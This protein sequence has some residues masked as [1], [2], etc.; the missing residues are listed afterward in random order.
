MHKIQFKIDISPNKL[1]KVSPWFS[2]YLLIVKVSIMCGIFGYCGDADA[3]ETILTGLKRLEYRGYDSWGVAVIGKDDSK[4]I[5]VS[6]KI[7]A[8]GNLQ[9]IKKLPESHIGIG[10]TRWATH[11]GVTELNAHPHFS[12]DNSFVL[13]QNGI[14]ENY[15]DL[16]KQLESD[17]YKFKTQT[18]TEVIVKLIEQELL[19][20]QELFL[21]VRNAFLKLNGRNTII[22]LTADN[23]I[24]AVRNGSPLVIGLGQN[25]VFFASDALS[26]ADKTD[27]VVFVENMQMIDYQDNDLSLFELESLKKLKLKKN[28][29]DHDAVEVSKEGFDHYM[30]KEILEQ[31]DTLF[32]SVNYTEEEFHDLVKAA[33]K[34]KNIFVLGSGGAF[35]AADQVA[36]L[37]RSIAGVKALGLRPYEINS[38]LQLIEDNDLLVVISQSGETADN[39]E[40]IEL[41]D[42]KI[43]IAST[44]NMIGSTT[45]RIS[46][47]PFYSRTGPEICV[48]STKSGTAQVAFGYLLANS[49]IGQHN[50]AKDSVMRLT[51]YLKEYLSDDFLR[52]IKKIA[53]KIKSK[54]HAFLL[55][56]GAN[57]QVA[58]LGALNIKEASYMHAEGFAAG[59]LKHG[60]IALIEKGTPVISFVDDDQDREYMIGATAEVKA[61]GAYVIGIGTEN[62]ELFDEFIELP[63]VSGISAAKIANVIPCQVLAY[64]IAT[65]RGFDPDKPRNLAKSVT[66]K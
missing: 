50:I 29:L 12:N 34:A 52:D 7:G 14:V 31:K 4:D 42:K 51:D 58:L 53:K 47:Y 25:E 41:I 11:G 49:I 48:L 57:Y 5:L 56:K 66:V 19:T 44:V 1:T 20:E 27:E 63:T 39:L 22:L 62:N 10:H 59:E 26:F 21:A 54:K 23:R 16:K 60:V 2:E 28:K 9:D 15:Q 37:L 38:Y 17:G 30:L 6:K 40:A 45:S 46:D 43:K 18:D 32:S 64:Y 3:A 65:E 13:A 61:R 36:Y 33:K 8:I 55:G 24:I 35:Y